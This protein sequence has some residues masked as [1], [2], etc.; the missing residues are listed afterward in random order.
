ML[1][2]HVLVKIS[3]I[4]EI[5]KLLLLKI[6]RCLLQAIKGKSLFPAR[7]AESNCILLSLGEGF[8]S[9]HGRGDLA[10]PFLQHEIALHHCIGRL[11]YLTI[12]E[13][14]NRARKGNKKS[15]CLRND[16]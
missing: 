1:I 11:G 8:F 9:G 7:D 14:L 5:K 13:K 12:N 16:P 6:R 3:V 2:A 15:W 4:H 10:P